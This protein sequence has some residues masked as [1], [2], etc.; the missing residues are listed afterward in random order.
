[1]ELRDC[2]PCLRKYLRFG[3]ARRSGRFP[4]PPHYADLQ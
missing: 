1:V 2:Q 4:R 3:T